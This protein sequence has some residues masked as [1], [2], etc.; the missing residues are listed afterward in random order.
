[1]QRSQNALDAV[2]ALD[3]ALTLAAVHELEPEALA[4]FQSILF[5]WSEIAAMELERRKEVR[6]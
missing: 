5:H 1:M 6:S 2:L 4:K 3:R